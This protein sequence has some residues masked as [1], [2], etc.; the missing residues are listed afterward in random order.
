MAGMRHTTGTWLVVLAL[1]GAAAFVH[2]TT[3][4]AQ[5]VFTYGRLGGSAVFAEQTLRAPAFGF[6]I[7]AELDAFAIDVSGLNFALEHDPFN[8]SRNVAAGS[9]L[10][11]SALRFLKPDAAASPY[12]GAGLSLG[13]ISFGRDES[14]T[15]VNGVT[16]GV[17]SW[18]GDGL[19]SELTVGYEIGRGSAVRIFVQADAALPFFRAASHT[20]T[21]ASTTGVD[22]RYVPSVV[23][24]VGVGWQRR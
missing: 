4:M 8:D 13:V 22:Y 6:G 19:Q 5:Q 2:P 14:G 9:W 20:Y 23:M 1:I 10:K 16:S 17:T 15:R 24:S 3:A 11:L 12:L 18:H 7:R 21:F